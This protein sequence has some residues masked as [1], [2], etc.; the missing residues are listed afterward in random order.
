MT[1]KSYPRLGETV[2][3]ET[4][5]NGLTV[6]VVPR[7]GFSKKLCY[8]V[9]DYGAIHTH[10]TENGKE[11]VAP[12]GVAHYLEHKMFDM[13]EGEISSQFAAMG[14]DVNAFTSYDMTAY[15]F[16]CTEQF[17]KALSLLLKFVSTPY[18][19][20]ES[21]QKEQGII[22]Q[23]IEMNADSPDTAVFERLM[24]CMYENHPINTP[25]LGTRETIA[26]ITPQVLEKCH[27]AFYSP[28]NML[29]CVVGD[30]DPEQV[31][32]IAREILPKGKKEKTPRTDRWEEPMTVLRHSTETEMEVAMPLFQLGFKCPDPGRGEAAVR[33]EFVADLACEALFGESSDLYLRMYEEGIIDNSFGGGFETV[34]GMGM[35][36]VSGDS[37]YPEK[38]REA[39]MAEAQRLCREGIPEESLLRMKRSAMGRRIRA[40]DSGSSLIFRICAYYFSG[41]DYLQFPAIYERITASELTDFLCV[42]V[43]EENCAISVIR[44]INKEEKK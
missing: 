19:T 31:C 37:H 27:K 32:T 12:A 16:S 1:E 9:T 26:E 3:W 34:S 28:E 2:F 5:E 13:P 20:E 14:A 29:L 35:L 6:A 43:R 36:S 7:P 22:G 15:Y 23:E 4:L 30:V 25:I 33:Q 24:G 39:I 18:F 42:A 21:V 38:V 17:E 40:L 44:P 41:F 10:F 8:F 11:V